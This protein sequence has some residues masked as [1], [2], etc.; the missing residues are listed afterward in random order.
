MTQTE[1]LST[2]ELRWERR[3]LWLGVP[4]FVLFVGALAFSNAVNLTQMT[5]TEVVTFFE[6]N[7]TRILIAFV[8]IALSVFFLLWFLGAARARLA[9][10]GVA[11][12]RLATTSLAA[13]VAFATL[14]LAGRAAAGAPTGIFMF[15]FEDAALDPVAASLLTYLGYDLWALAGVA[16]SVSITTMAIAGE[17]SKALPRWLIWS[18]Y[19]AA[20]VALISIVFPYATLSVAMLWFAGVSGVLAA[21]MQRPAR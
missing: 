13:G 1:T 5:A 11:A 20:L 9:R 21:R 2:Q 18:G 15:G 14:L 10:E 17:L 16:A 4:A 6:D 12:E 8:L 3:D 7:Q 19:V